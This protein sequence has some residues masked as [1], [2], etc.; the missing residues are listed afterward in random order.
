MPE[1]MLSINDVIHTIAVSD[2]R[3]SWLVEGQP[4]IGK[5]S[6]VAD[7]AKRR[8]ELFGKPH[9]VYILDCTCADVGDVVIPNMEVVNGIQ[10]V[11]YAPNSAFGVGQTNPVVILLDE[12]GKAMK[13]VQDALLPVILEH[14]VGSY[15]LPEGSLVVATTNLSTDGV[16]DLLPPHARNRVSTLVMRNPTADEW[17]QW[18]VNHDVEPVVIA[19]A[20]QFPAVFQMYCESDANKNPYIFDPIHHPERAAFATPRSLERAGWLL[21]SRRSVN[22]AAMIAAL[23]GTVGEAFARDMVTLVTLS[24]SLTPPDEVIK[25]PKDVPIPKEAVGQLILGLNVLRLGTPKTA[26]AIIT[27]VQ[28]LKAEVRAVLATTMLEGS[29]QTTYMMAPNLNELASSLLKYQQAS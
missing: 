20:R 12:W 14:R 25:K 27:F 4:G 26:Q 3:L 29:Y 22:P 10:Q 24:D 16:G 1:T 17:M 23:A 11:K 13:P 9:D 8:S 5:S 21:Q 19:A 28:R 18:A 15:K 7:I 6:M 2:N